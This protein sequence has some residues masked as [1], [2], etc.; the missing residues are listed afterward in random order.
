MRNNFT[1][2]KKQPEN[3]LFI[4]KLMVYKLLRHI[5]IQMKAQYSAIKL[6]HNSYVVI[7]MYDSLVIYLL[8]FYV[9]PSFLQNEI[10]YFF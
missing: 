10:W 9:N 6:A 7:V 2:N 5:S 1:G 3:K 8:F 4:T